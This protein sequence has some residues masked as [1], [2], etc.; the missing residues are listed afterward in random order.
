M[1]GRR[2]THTCCNAGTGCNR[3]PHQ[4]LVAGQRGNKYLLENAEVRSSI[5]R[6]GYKLDK[7]AASQVVATELPTELK[8]A[9]SLME[10][11]D[12]NLYTF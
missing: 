3:R 4:S 8:L 2:E 11:C 10:T 7:S 6:G 9:F 5:S 12:G 1:I